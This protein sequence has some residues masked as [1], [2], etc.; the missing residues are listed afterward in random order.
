MAEEKKTAALPILGDLHVALREKAEGV[1]ALASGAKSA[2]P[3]DTVVTETVDKIA[4]PGFYLRRQLPRRAH[5]MV[6]MVEQVG[7][8]VSGVRRRK[9]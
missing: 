2:L 5:Q 8:A 1:S 9:K 6:R 4:K 3:P 7:Q